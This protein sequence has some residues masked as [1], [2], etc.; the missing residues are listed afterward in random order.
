MST[1]LSLSSSPLT[2]LGSASYKTLL[3]DDYSVN[4]LNFK[5]KANTK[6]GGT[7]NYKASST[8]EVFDGKES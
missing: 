8:L 6:N 5:A 7:V 2:D 1:P 4:K 3:E